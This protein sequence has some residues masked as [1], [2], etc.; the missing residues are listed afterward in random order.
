MA[1]ITES[2]NWTWLPFGQR[3][4]SAN[5]LALDKL[6]LSPTLSASNVAELLQDEIDSLNLRR[7]ANDFGGRLQAQRSA[8]HE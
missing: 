2:A 7:V 6:L 3:F 1:L 4:D 5:E 8:K